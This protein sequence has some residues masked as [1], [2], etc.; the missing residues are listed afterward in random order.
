VDDAI[1][2][3]ENVHRLMEEENLMPK[4]A[5]IKAMSQVSGPI[6]ATTLVLLAVFV[7]IAFMPGITGQ[8]YKQF[9]VT[10]CISV[11]LSAINSLTLS[12]ALCGVFLR[13]PKII[14]HGP[15]G[16][17]NVYMDWSRRVYSQVVAWFIRHLTVAILIFLL[18]IASSL[19][20]SKIIPTSF[21]PL[22]DKGGFSMM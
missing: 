19:L 1:V 4:Q 13:K 5:A 16:W 21:L 20:L 11:V 3:V 15:F 14:K 9:G 6:I 2:V 10:I 7:P 17:F 22:E 18:I 12:P 8:L